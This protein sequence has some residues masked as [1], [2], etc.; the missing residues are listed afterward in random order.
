[1]AMLVYTI[2]RKNLREMFGYKRY[3]Y[4]F[5]TLASNMS[6]ISTS[7]FQSF[8]FLVT[9]YCL[10]CIVNSS[11]LNETSFKEF[12]ERGSIDKIISLFVT[13]TPRVIKIDMQSLTKTLKCRLTERNNKSSIV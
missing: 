7:Y 6:E 9:S 12:I 3:P 2:Y 5:Y 10:L 13:I 1:M 4:S 11:C 8:Q